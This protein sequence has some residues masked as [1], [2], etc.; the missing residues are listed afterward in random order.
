LSDKFS[1]G[2]SI[3]ELI[4]YFFFTSISRVIVKEVEEMKE[5]KDFPVIV[6]FPVAWGDMDS[7]GH[8]NNIRFFKYFESARIKY[9]EETGFVN[10]MHHTKIGPILASTSAK[11]IKPIV[12]PDTILIGTKITDLF[13]Q[14]FSM[15]YII[16]SEKNG[17]VAVGEALIVIL[18]YKTSKKVSLPM[19]V[20][21]KIL[22]LQPELK[23]S[24]SID[25]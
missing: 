16:E 21:E 19:N 6:K 18:D 4:Y 17:V 7:F 9:F 23:Q 5:L 15:D 2:R 24:Q 12:Y 3:D 20:K 8:V 25:D 10:S 14:K 22:D 1:H 13:D 11:F